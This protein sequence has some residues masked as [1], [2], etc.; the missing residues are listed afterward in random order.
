M[1]EVPHGKSVSSL[2]LAAMRLTN[3]LT[4]VAALFVPVSKEEAGQS[5]ETNS[6]KM[7]S[8]D[9]EDAVKAR[10]R[11]SLREDEGAAFGVWSEPQRSVTIP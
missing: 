6:L 9:S 10:L 3:P 5:V 7:F 1:I 4:L 8:G 2:E 11:V